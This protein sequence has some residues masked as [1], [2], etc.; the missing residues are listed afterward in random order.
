VSIGATDPYRGTA[1]NPRSPGCGCRPSFPGVLLSGGWICRLLS[2]KSWIHGVRRSWCQTYRFQYSGMRMHPNQFFH[3]VVRAS[4]RERLGGGHIVW[5]VVKRTIS[6]LILSVARQ[7]EVGR[8]SVSERS[9]S[10]NECT[11]KSS[12]RPAARQRYFWRIDL[13]P[14][15]ILAGAKEKPRGNRKQ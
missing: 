7:R 11:Q 15:K 4:D 1:I 6:R 10:V 8:S 3:H 13:A 5:H 12:T 9:K 14:V 2:S